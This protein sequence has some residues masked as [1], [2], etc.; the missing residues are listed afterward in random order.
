MAATW[1]NVSRKRGALK[2]G[3]WV[4]IESQDEKEREGDFD[5]NEGKDAAGAE[6]RFYTLR[7]AASMPLESARRS[8]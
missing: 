4:K 1:W 3:V 2:E 8:H 5:G 6:G 7:H